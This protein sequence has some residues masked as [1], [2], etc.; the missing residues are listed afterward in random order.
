M[1]D[2]IASKLEDWEQWRQDNLN[3]LN[4]LHEWLKDK[5]LESKAVHAMMLG[6]KARLQSNELK[7]AFVGDFSRGKSELINAIFFASGKRRILPVSA[8][9]TT[10]CAVEIGYDKNLPPCIRLLPLMTRF[11]E[12]SLLDWTSDQY[13]DIW[14]TEELDTDDLDQ[15]A[16]VINRVSERRLV[17]PAE[18]VELGLWD[19]ENPQNNPPTNALGLLEVPKWRYAMINYPHPLL[20]RGI[21]IMDTPGL[22]AIGSE[23]ELT[24]DLLPQAH[25]ILYVLQAD[26]GVTRTDLQ[27]W[28]DYLS[29]AHT[30]DRPCYILLNKIDTLWDDLLSSEEVN[31][32][33]EQQRQIC[34]AMLD[35]PLAKVF[36]LSAQKGLVGKVNNDEA[37]LDKSQIL[38]VERMLVGE[39]LPRR[40]Q[41]VRQALG[42]GLGELYT[43][44]MD[45]FDHKAQ[46]LD[47]QIEELQAFKGKNE[48]AAK[49]IVERL[50]ERDAALSSLRKMASE[51]RVLESRALRRMAKFIA[52]DALDSELIELSV[53]INDAKMKVSLTKTFEKV[54]HLLRVRA[55]KFESMSHEFEVLVNSHLKK[56]EAEYG[57]NLTIMPSPGVGSLMTD[58][59][60]LEDR[61]TVFFE[62]EQMV[63][64]R[65]ANQTSR[66]YHTL[67]TRIRSIFD[68]AFDMLDMWSKSSYNA[69]VARVGDLEESTR[70][71]YESI[72]YVQI[73]K[74]P[75]DERIDAM[76]E[77]RQ[78]LFQQQV[79]L[80]KMLQEFDQFS[81]VWLKAGV[82]KVPFTHHVTPENQTPKDDAEPEQKEVDVKKREEITVGFVE[83]PQVVTATDML[84]EAAELSEAKAESDVVLLFEHFEETLP[85]ADDV[86]IAGGDGEGGESDEDDD[87]LTLQAGAADETEDVAANGYEDGDRQF[88][89]EVA[90]GH[91]KSAG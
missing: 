45:R 31:V 49:Q 59:D 42:T 6:V 64:L 34:A 14:I 27:I 78:Q 19:M 79:D 13:K 75:L 9:R 41:I 22:N 5:K 46:V 43:S 53:G 67:L 12:M 1:S 32:Q 55:K 57:I 24:L 44:V 18:A 15:F 86:V 33:L 39:M 23:L 65:R 50:D 25:V 82:L 66:V 74:E 52:H 3:R 38:N 83:S 87:A 77:E 76:E 89:D 51:M 84:P 48:A 68:E 21:S 80:G 85:A 71:L 7:I 35:I 47:A 28:E 36:A 91:G 20:K 56:L 2:V 81:P 11:Q 4:V 37:L 30:A 17:S 62:A 69:L 63:R 10:M 54:V 70:E 29:K 88:S 40:Q 8:G 16:M 72:K 90:Q 58:L 61:H 26:T 60:L 73:S